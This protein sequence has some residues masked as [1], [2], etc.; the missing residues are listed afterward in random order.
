MQLI[1]TDINFRVAVVRMG[2]VSSKSIE[3]C[4]KVT[5]TAWTICVAEIALEYRLLER[6]RIV[7]GYKKECGKFSHTLSQQGGEVGDEDGS[8]LERYPA[9]NL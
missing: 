2:E 7:K 9:A 6:E 4:D 3:L 8:H 5:Y 1:F